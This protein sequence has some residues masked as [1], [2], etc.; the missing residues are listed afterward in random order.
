MIIS[1]KTIKTPKKLADFRA[2]MA[3]FR[4]RKPRLNSKKSKEALVAQG[5]HRSL[6][7]RKLALLPGDPATA[8][9]IVHAIFRR[10]RRGN[11]AAVLWLLRRS[12]Q[13][14]VERDRQAA[15]PPAGRA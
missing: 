1:A 12:D 8:A 3:N 10:A 11:S 13:A 7:G 15:Q 4:R 14:L 9:A 6:S 5:G 2:P